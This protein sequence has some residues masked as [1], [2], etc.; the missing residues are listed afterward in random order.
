MQGNEDKMASKARDKLTA[1]LRAKLAGR[2]L[3]MTWFTMG[4]IPLLEIAT[5]QG[6]DVALIDAQH[7]LWDRMT[8]YGAV[9]ASATP[10]MVRTA[11]HSPLHIGEAL[12]SGAFGILAPSVVNA[13]QAKAI[14]SAARYPPVGIR[15]GGGVTP[16]GAGFERYY[17]QAKD[18]LIGVMIETVEGVANASAIA[19]VEGVDFLFIGTG[20]LSF[21]VGC[22]PEVDERL[23]DACKEVFEACRFRNKPCGI[24]TRSHEAAFHRRDEGYR[25]VVI[26]DDIGIV[27]TGFLNAG[28]AIARHSR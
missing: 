3:A 11:D 14:V 4:S 6:G 20:D 23:E 13:D 7:G 12:D 24:L 16:L 1:G 8:L 21:S 5:Q 10:V 17:E 18:P 9:R 28:Q 25:V 2:G 27:K 19:A 22:F 15:S 26:A